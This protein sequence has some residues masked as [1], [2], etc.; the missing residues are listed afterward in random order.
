MFKKMQKTQKFFF[1]KL[2]AL[3]SK[4]SKHLN[5]FH[6]LHAPNKMDKVDY[7]F[8]FSTELLVLTLSLIMIAV[9]S[10]GIKGPLQSI[11]TSTAMSRE[12]SYRPANN[13][14]LYNKN[15]TITTVVKASE[16]FIPTASAK[17][18]LASDQLLPDS[19]GSNVQ[20]SIIDNNAI[21]A[22]QQANIR[23]MVANQIKNYTVVS[24][25]TLEGLS[26]K[27][28]ISQ[29]TIIWANNLD[30]KTLKPGMILTILPIDGVAR[31]V[32]DNDTL[33]DIAKLYKADVN[34][35]ISYNGL[36]DESDINP[37][38]LLIIPGGIIPG[39]DK[40]KV[41]PQTLKKVVRGKTVYTPVI[42][43]TPGSGHIFPWGQCTYYVAFRRD[44]LGKPVT[45][46]GNA[47]QWLRNAIAAGADTGSVPVPGAIMVTNDS[48]RYGHVAIVERVN[49]DG[50]ILVS[51]MNYEHLG[52]IDQRV[53]TH[54][55]V[56]Y[57]Y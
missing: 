15:T 35:I 19:Q 32:T 40:P 29:N 8:K 16:G 7:T 50:G 30:V 23:D 26:K 51:E 11:N 52:V 21:S 9:N 18:V 5:S 36:A 34:Q 20:N 49:D 39:S 45:W 17:V 41:K 47:K 48:R 57:I 25:D 43:L 12:L 27:Y 31:T 6:A 44:A 55:V 14:L 24:G 13:K 10:A 1:L 28:G 3:F 42:N 2:K 22:D 53:V 37:G 56:G 54:G 33:R 38:D 46:G 4:I